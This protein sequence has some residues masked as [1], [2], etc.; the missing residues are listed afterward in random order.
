MPT[1]TAATTRITMSHAAP[2]PLSAGGGLVV[3]EA[4]MMIVDEEEATA[5]CSETLGEPDCV[6]DDCVLEGDGSAVSDADGFAGFVAL[7]VL[8]VSVGS[9]VAVDVEVVVDASEEVDVE[10]LVGSEGVVDPAVGN[11]MDGLVSDG[12][13]DTA[14]ETAELRLPDPHAAVT[15][16]ISG[17]AIHM[18]GRA[19]HRRP[20]PSGLPRTARGYRGTRYGDRGPSVDGSEVTTEVA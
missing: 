4:T 16:P 11:A 2:L 18:P 9:T 13:P 7:E 14:E 3:G 1:T 5:V 6:E 12:R 15:R 20:A 8:D 17:R 19:D 10:V